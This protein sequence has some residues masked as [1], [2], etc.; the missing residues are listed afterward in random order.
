MS[1]KKAINEYLFYAFGYDLQ[2]DPS[3]VTE[4]WPF[5]L[6]FLGT[7]QSSEGKIEVFQFTVN[8]QMY[9]VT[10]GSTLV[11]YPA[12]GMTLDDLQVQH[13]GATWITHQNPVDLATSYLGDTVVPPVTERRAV[14]EL[15]AADA[16]TS[17]QILEGLYLQ[18]LEI[19]LA[20]IEDTQT[21]VGIIIGTDLEKCY[22]S[23][24]EASAWRRLALGIGKM[25]QEGILD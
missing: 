15:L 9:F 4:V 7:I 23:F 18:R 6:Q 25:L 14:I 17:P 5:R 24:P 13:N 2:Q 1:E 8:E 3:M 11:Y 10:S 16:C 20:L 19:Y 22:I 21:G 12:A